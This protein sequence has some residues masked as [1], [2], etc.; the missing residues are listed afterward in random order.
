ME[1]PGHAGEAEPQHI[2]FLRVVADTPPP[3]G[4]PLPAGPVSGALPTPARPVGA[5][6]FARVSWARWGIL[7]LSVSLLGVVRTY[8]TH[9]EA[10]LA[11]EAEAR[12]AA[13]AMQVSSPDGW[14]PAGALRL[15]WDQVP[16]SYLYR[17]RITTVTGHLV[18]DQLAV[19]AT[20]WTPPA[21]LLPALTR[22]EYTWEVSAIGPDERPIARSG[23]IPLYLLD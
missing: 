6:G 11:R 13:A 20:E 2:P 17:L 9:T 21:E 19:Q 12:E 16:G 22:G 7:A 10:R 14:V 3:A 8:A 4:I 23:P 1:R 5:P 15:S 18:V